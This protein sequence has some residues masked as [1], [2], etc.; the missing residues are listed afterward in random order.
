MQGVIGPPCCGRCAFGRYQGSCVANQVAIR[1][2]LQCIQGVHPFALQAPFKVCRLALL[3]ERVVHGHREVVDGIGCMPLA[4]A[5]NQGHAS[6]GEAE[7][8]K[9]AG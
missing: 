4:F 5:A 3:A 8:A 1:A 6:Q 7:Q 9:K 2:H